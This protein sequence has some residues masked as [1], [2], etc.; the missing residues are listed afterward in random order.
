MPI[1]VNVR[2]NKNI[3]TYILKLNWK[4]KRKKNWSLT[5]RR[6]VD[7]TKE[8]TLDGCLAHGGGNNR[9]EWNPTRR[10][11]DVS[12]FLSCIMHTGCRRVQT[13]YPLARFSVSPRINRIRRIVGTYNEF[14]PPV[15]LLHYVAASKREF[16]ASLLR[17]F[18]PF[19]RGTRTICTR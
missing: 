3:R 19:Q 8:M 12:F 11:I 16:P 17:R 4:G 13:V 2:L 7:R 18:R 10:W 1:F 6:I 9:L 15:K 14:S 5:K